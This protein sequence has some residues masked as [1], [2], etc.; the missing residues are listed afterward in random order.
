VFLR[1]VGVGKPI[2][3]FV[4][5]KVPDPNFFASETGWAWFVLRPEAAGQG[6]A[7]AG[8][9]DQNSQAVSV[10]YADPRVISH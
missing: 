4:D 9:T 8:S 7:G 1:S 5:G 10:L 6:S 2:G 3:L